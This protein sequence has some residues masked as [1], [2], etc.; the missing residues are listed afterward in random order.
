MQLIPKERKTTGN[1]YCTWDA[2]CDEM[3]RRDPSAERIPSRDAMCEDFLFGEHG[4]LTR[5]TGV[6]GDLIAV[7]D[8]GW[9][10]PF[11]ATDTRVFGSLEADEERFPSLRGLQPAQRL[12]ALSERVRALGYRGLGLWV[13]TQTPSLVGGKEVILSPQEERLYWE[14]RARWCNEAGVVYLKAD[15][16]AHQGDAAYCQ[17]MTECMRRFAPG[18]AIEH[19]LVGRPL[20]ESQTD[21]SAVPDRVKDYLH[22]VLSNCDYFR[23]Y[24]VVHELKYASTIDRAS[25][26]L[27]A[28]QKIDGPCAVLNIED[29]GLIGAALGCAVG[30]M[31]HDFEKERKYLPLPARLVSET[32]C[33]LRWQRIAP[34]VAANVGSLQIARERL[35]DVWHCPKRP[36]NLWPSKPEGDYYVT[37]PAAVARNMPLPQ[38]KAKGEKPYV[39]CSAHPQTGA[40]CVA[41]TPRT[42]GSRIDVAVPAEILL[43]GKKTDVPIGLFGRFETLSIDFEE[44]AEGCRVFA[45]SLLSDTA[46]E[47]TGLVSLCGNRLT[48]PG[49]FM[50]AIGEPEDRENGIPAIVLRLVR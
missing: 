25:L 13:P 12:K 17:M 32:V 34:P 21:G 42:F 6:R 20:F 23:T 3:Y 10:V 47:V 9:D 11:G 8:D 48:V 2:Q 7:L 5:F 4:V 19:G 22:E 50:L 45:Q 29:T 39:V 35:K 1:Y 40:L 16:G 24:D 44:K 15:W 43:K 38:V 31:R 18:L 36:A 33:A 28:A 26:C 27:A 41:V 49:S 14:E 30:V 37:A 46:K